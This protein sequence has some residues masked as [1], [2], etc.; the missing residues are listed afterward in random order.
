VKKEIPMTPIKQGKY[1]FIHEH[2]I[3]VRNQIGLTQK[4]MA[5]KLGIPANT[6]L[7]WEKGT[8]VPD[9]KYL[10]A[11][12]SIAKEHGITPSFF[13]IPNKT[14][15]FKYNL[16]VIWDFQAIG[17]PVSW[18]QYEDKII[19]T[20][21]QKRFSG[22]IPL[23][24]AF[25][26]P[27]QKQAAIE[28]EKLGWRVFEGQNEIFDDIVG[29]ARSDSGQNPEMTMV[30]L[31]SRDD[32]F[33]ELIDEL[34]SNK[35]TVYIMSPPVLNNKLIEKVGPMNCIP[36]NPASSETPKRPIANS[37]NFLWEIPYSHGKI[38]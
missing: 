3:D 7:R 24:K 14:K 16:V 33:V 5:E 1:E 31:I 29:Q 26:H 27:S 18:V 30:V 6:L 35:V 22:L 25:T 11:F 23:M 17:T 9:A 21:L 20:E 12:Y 13:G 32:K 37:F 36:W 2:L 34:T 8:T 38:F 28:L 19:R 15:S 4:S 10:A